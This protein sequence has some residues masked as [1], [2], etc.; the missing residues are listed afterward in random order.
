MPCSCSWLS[1]A[2]GNRRTP[3]PFSDTFPIFLD[4][5]FVLYASRATIDIGNEDD[6]FRGQR[7]RLDWHRIGVIPYL[8]SSSRL[9]SIARFHF[10]CLAKVGERVHLYQFNHPLRTG[11]HFRILLFPPLLSDLVFFSKFNVCRD[12]YFNIFEHRR[13]YLRGTMKITILHAPRIL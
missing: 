4:A 11:E 3:Q 12:I 13:V 1:L 7:N 5:S 10:P 6:S 2:D 8:L 9:K